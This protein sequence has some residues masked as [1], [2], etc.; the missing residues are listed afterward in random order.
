MST[1]KIVN[2]KTLPSPRGF[3]HGVSARGGSFLFVAGQIGCNEKGVVVSSDIVDQAEKALHNVL[4]VVKEAGGSPTSIVR[5]TI[6]VTDLVE[7]RARL[8]GLGE[9]YKRVMGKHF[10]AM[11]LIQVQALFEQSARIEVE[12]TAVL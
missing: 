7:Y 8:K 6:Y 11:A 4:E 12:A 1:P 10:P 3:N 9:A 5:L 2:P